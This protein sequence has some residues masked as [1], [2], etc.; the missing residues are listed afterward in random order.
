MA[1]P[2][3]E[4]SESELRALRQ[5]LG[6]FVTGVTIVTTRAEDGSWRGITVNSFTSVSLRPPRV[7]V[8][9]DNRAASFP[10]FTAASGYVIN[11]LGAEDQELATRFA[12]K[13]P[14]KFDGI[15]VEQSPLGHPILRAATTWIECRRA[16]T[17]DI[18]DH[19]VLIGAVTDYA[20]RGG[21]PLAFH[22][23]RFVSFAPAPQLADSG[24][25][26]QTIRAGWIVET[27]QGSVAL[28]HLPDG[29]LAIPTAPV[30]ARQLSERSLC[31]EGGALVGAPMTIEFLYSAYNSET[32]GQ[33]TMVYRS[34]TDRARLD[35]DRASLYPLSETTLS[36]IASTVE[37]SVLRR[38]AREREGPTFGIYSGTELSGNVVQ[39]SG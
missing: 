34:T 7:L 36:R 29:R 4:L 1:D 20:E 8:C 2:H 15:E 13:R 22:Q 26:G 10:V 3:R 25:E 37:R 33:L 16:E 27:P 17:I 28:T 32:S 24:G 30:H 14:D 19:A 9:V 35:S 18:G 11:I 23:G 39:L 5:A 12:S 31:R 6:A 21:Q 38:Y